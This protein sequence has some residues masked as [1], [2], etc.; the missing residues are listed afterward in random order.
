MDEMRFDDDVVIVTGAGRGLG[1]EYALAFAGRGAS[2]V[3]NDLGSSQEGQDK[4][5]SVAQAVVD[6]IVSSGGRA[7]AD[8]HS[9]ADSDGAHAIVDRALEAFG[10]VTVLV[11][12]AGVIDYAL[13]PDI[14]DAVWDRMIEVTLRG[15]FNTIRS[16]WPHFA[17]QE[18]GRIVNTTSNVGFAGNELLVHYGAAKLG[19]AGLTR[20]LAQETGEADIR[21]NAVAPMAVTRMNR[22]AFFGGQESAGPD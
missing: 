13:L 18:Y 20:S 15:T 8:T 9:V 4:D 21:V 1:R 22:E 12:N 10:K 14:T 2:V 5:V 11:N 6:E 19:V 7:V 17:D 3:V 16:A